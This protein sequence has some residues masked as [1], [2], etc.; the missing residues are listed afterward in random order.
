MAEEPLTVYEHRLAGIRQRIADT[1]R[2]VSRDPDE[3]TL[4]V[5]S[6]F[7]PA[8]VVRT[9]ASLGI[10]DFGE[11]RHQEAKEKAEATADLDLCWH[12]VGQLQSNKARQAA[13]YASA[14]H[15]L[16][17]EAIVDALAKYEG[18]IDG[19]LQ[20]NLTDDPGRGGV[21]PQ[22]I[23]RLAERVLETANITLRGVMAVAPLDEEPAS[24]FARLREYSERVS[25]LAPH[26]TQISAGMTHDFETA[27]EF[28]A[29]H[30]R[31]GSAI[32]GNR[33]A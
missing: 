12:F 15:S 3:V 20:I 1:C 23:E 29:T 2:R 22:D 21:Q 4:I 31:I 6:K 28:G 16:D 30:L 5:V 13:R 19:F 14:I 9:L 7:H 27:L 25:R 33:P 10:R 26:A 24:A 17:R 8:S 18:E 11:N 32:T